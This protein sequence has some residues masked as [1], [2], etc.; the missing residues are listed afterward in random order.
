[1]TDKQKQTGRFFPHIEPYEINA[2]DYL[3]LNKSKWTVSAA[4][5]A[6]LIYDMQNWYVDRYADPKPLL[7]NIGRLREACTRAGMPVFFAAARKVRTLAERGIAYDLWG[8]GIGAVE[9]AEDEDDAFPSVLTPAPSDFVV[10]KRKYSAF[11]DTDFETLLR[12][13]NR[14]QLIICGVYA[15]HG[16]MI[17]AVEAYMRNFKVFFVADALGDM[18][19]E[20]HDMALRYVAEVCGQIA[21]TDQIIDRLE[22]GAC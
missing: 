19:P 21:A 4:E 6:L 22:N 5:A 13:T 1:M 12:H 10:P 15:R 18:S 9:D 14:S 2:E 20:G 3:K 17:T 16:C 11:Y 8:P 7:A